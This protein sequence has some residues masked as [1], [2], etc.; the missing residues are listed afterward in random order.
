M[1]I[2]YAAVGK[3]IKMARNKIG[4]T[5]EKLAELAHL[6]TSHVSKI[7]TG[8]TKLGLPTIVDIAN[9]LHTSVDALLAD[10]VVYPEVFLKKDV[11]ALLEGLS[12]SELRIMTETMTALR[13]SMIAC[14]PEKTE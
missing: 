14:R 5:Q 8:D 12:R 7:E 4:I 11:E 3:R 10:S 2:D 9:A 1:S 13:R 6:S